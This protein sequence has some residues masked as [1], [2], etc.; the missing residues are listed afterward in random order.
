M[1]SFGGASMYDWLVAIPVWGDSYHELFAQHIWPTIKDAASR[2]S[3]HVRYV[4]HTDRPEAIEHLIGK[5]A[6]AQF[7]WPSAGEDWQVYSQSHREAANF[8]RTGEI[9]C[10]L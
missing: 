6:D 8:A 1:T 9:V 2:A 7:L 10:F 5:G 4:F 3:G